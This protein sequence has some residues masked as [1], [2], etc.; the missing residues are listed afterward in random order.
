MKP[1]PATTVDPRPRITVSR[2][3]TPRRVPRPAPGVAP[4]QTLLRQNDA[5]KPFHHQLE[6][7]ATLQKTLFDAVPTGLRK[8]CRVAALEGSLVVVAAANGAVAAKLKQML[9]RLLVQFCEHRLAAEPITGISVIVQPEYF[10]V[11][12]PTK[13]LPS[14]APLPMEKLAQ[15]AASLDDSPLKH[16]LEAIANQRRRAS[17]AGSQDR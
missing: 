7:I 12:A 3:F 2:N 16:A 5:L 10:V 13:A 15:L 1:K 6:Q 8:G 4:I 11:A 17:K 9:P 14:R